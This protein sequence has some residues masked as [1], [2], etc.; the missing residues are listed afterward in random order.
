VL[1]GA[2]AITHVT[3]HLLVLEDLARILTITR[4]T[5]RTVAERNTVSCTEAS[6]TP[7]LHR[8]CNALALRMPGDVHLLTGNEVLSADRGANRQ[9]PVLAVDAKF[10]N[11]L[12][13]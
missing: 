11:L 12:L 6:E 1:L 8:A 4:R 3:C 10:S 9:K 13:Q 2:L 5:M 7:A